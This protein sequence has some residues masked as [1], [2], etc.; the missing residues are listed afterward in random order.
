ML[1]EIQEPQLNPCVAA[2]NDANLFIYLEIFRP[3]LVELWTP[4]WLG[5]DTEGSAHEG[6]ISQKHLQMDV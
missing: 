2:I 6:S 4:L 5:W 3:C 1:A